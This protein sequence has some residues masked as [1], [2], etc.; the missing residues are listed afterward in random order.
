MAFCN[1]VRPTQYEDQVTLNLDFPEMNPAGMMAFRVNNI[2]IDKKELIDSISIYMPLC[3]GRDY[4]NIKAVLHDNGGGFLVTEPAVPFYMI[5]EVAQLHSL[6][7]KNVCEDAMKMHKMVAT[8]ISKKQRHEKQVHFL[9]P[10]G[11]VCKANHFSN[12]KAKMKMN[13]RMMDILLKKGDP[14][15]QTADVVQTVAFVF[16]RIAIDQEA[17]HLERAASE[18]LEDE[19]TKATQCMSQMQI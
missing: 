9:F 6:E 2:E 3:D 10:D 16:W 4:K 18:D 12:S 13:F 17:R 19:F 5:K 8:A 11:I 1:S 15:L 14:Q 7:G